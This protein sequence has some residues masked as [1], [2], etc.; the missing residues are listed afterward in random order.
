LAE[1]NLD[2]I[3]VDISL[4]DTNFMGTVAMTKAV[5][6][7]MITRKEGHI[8]NVNSVSGVIGT[9]M[10]TAYSASKFAMTGYF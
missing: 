6:A 8:V 4:M 10:R 1:E 9:P 5:L 3:D 7:Q 2:S